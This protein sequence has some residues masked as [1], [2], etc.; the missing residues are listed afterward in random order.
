MNSNFYK[1]K[2][3]QSVKNFITE[4][5]EAI[6]KKK[7]FTAI[8]LSKTKKILGVI[9]RGD[10]RRLILNNTSL[11]KKIDKFL[12]LRPI[13]VKIDELNNNLFSNLIQKSKGKVFDD[14][15]L[16]DENN[17]FLK[18]LKYN[19]IK[20]NFN[21]KNTCV[22]GMGH[23]GLPLS[24]FILKK[25]KN[26]IGYDISKKK[27]DD[28]KKNN[29]GFHEK[30]LEKLIINH[31]KNK[32]LKLIDKLNDCNSEVY[33]VCIGTIIKNKKIINKN[34]KD[35]ART[36]SRKIKK[37][38]LVILRGTVSVGTSRELFLKN[39]IKFSNLKNGKDFYFSFM[40]ER[41]VEGNALE[42]LEKV[43]QLVSGSTQKCLQVAYDYSKEIFQNVLK[44]E[45]LEEGEIIKLASNSFRSLNFAFSNEISRI[46][47]LYG[48]SGSELI[49]KANFGYERN[50]ISKPSLGIGG[51][52]LPKDPLLFSNNSKKKS[53]YKLGK[54]SH[55]INKEITSF[56]ISKFL[57]LLKKMNEPKIL[58]MGLSFKGVPETLDMRNSTSLEIIKILLKN[59]YKCHAYDPLG[60]ILNKNFKIKNLKILNNN[61]DINKYDLI[62]IVNDHPKF[63]E[64]I[65]SKLKENRSSKRKYIFDTW[66]NIDK[67]FV[68]NLGWKYLNI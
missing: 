24:V 26:V 9:S 49:K 15:L 45:S 19:E 65:E 1:I 29:L 14:I 43:P 7:I 32:R 67:S 21:Y 8:K 28:I 46:S 6:K 59:K 63:F 60:H 35:L 20:D 64:K 52:C 55:D 12:N 4:F 68:E 3:G 22:I 16:V 58:L 41:L 34:L 5:E 37:G 44:L 31:L 66:N 10:L 17:K 23:I 54:I 30:N 36:L 57:D 50:N 33:I 48:L 56:F 38:D 42:E 40:P 47:N 51:F 2:E 62:I 27:I 25:F 53:N 13:I 18:I 11:D 61:F 39:I